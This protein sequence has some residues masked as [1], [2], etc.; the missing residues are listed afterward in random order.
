MRRQPKPRAQ[1]ESIAGIAQA[2]P[3]WRGAGR[4]P[5]IAV[6]SALAV[7]LAWLCL[8]STVTGLVVVPDG[9]AYPADW[10]TL[11]AAAQNNWIR[12]HVVTLKGPAAAEH[13]LQHFSLFW[14]QFAAVGALTLSSALVALVAFALMHRRVGSTP[15]R[16]ATPRRA[17]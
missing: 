9:V 7:S 12:A 15:A 13:M 1:P 10:P 3:R 8:V 5:L 16:T 11:S 17:G 14:Q 2:T 6:L 4:I